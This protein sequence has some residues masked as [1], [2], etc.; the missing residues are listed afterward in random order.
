MEKTVTTPEK[1]AARMP[2]RIGSLFG[3]QF[4]ALGIFL[5]FFPIFLADRGLDDTEI[6]FILATPL[7]IRIAASPLVTAIADRFGRRVLALIVTAGASAFGFACYAFVD[8]FAALFAVAVFTSLFH[9][10]II[11]LSD[12]YA[13]DAVRSGIGDYGRMRLWGSVAFV[14]ATLAGGM[15]L[16]VWPSSLV[17]FG[18][19]GSM[20]AMVVVAATLPELGHQEGVTPAAGG[21]A[22]SL[23]N[24]V[25]LTVLLAVGLI[26]GSHAV[27][28]GFSSLH[29]R[30]AGISET[31]IGALWVVGVIVEIGLFAAATRLRAFVGPMTMVAIGGCAAVV[32]WLCFPFAE[33]VLAAFSLQILHGLT[34]G[35]THL[36]MIGFVA[37]SIPARRAATAQGLASTFGG[38]A[39][40]LGTL[41]A[42]PL[43]S[44]DPVIAFWS[45]AAGGA[46]ALVL[47]GAVA[48][49]R[50]ARQR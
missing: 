29:W 17:P 25:F 41:A 31:T 9:G 38:I 30:R 35:A 6:G 7:A 45:M 20:L 5:P 22:I 4:L 26:Q 3:F 18:L 8:G 28:Y 27:Y 44:A 21:P 39:T 33:S 40:A 47:L 19:A 10:A 12:A 1:Y 46:I 23:R 36:G 34:F 2:M 13:M 49:R 32:R 24:P 11:P 50:L 15:A 16:E 42:G 48:V 14:I 37:V 43:Y